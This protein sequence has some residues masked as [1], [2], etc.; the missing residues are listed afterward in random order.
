MNPKRGK[1][2]MRAFLKKR[3]LPAILSLS[4]GLSMALPGSLTALAAGTF[5]TN[6]TN[7]HGLSGTW[8]ETADGYH[9]VAYGPGGNSFAIAD[10]QVGKDDLFTYEAQVSST[11]T[12]PD[13]NASLI[14][15]LKNPQNPAE[16]FYDF[17]I[18]T[19]SNRYIRFDQINGELSS[20][21]LQA[22]ALAEVKDSYQL[23]IVRS[24]Q[25]EFEFFI[26]NASI[27]KMDLPGFEGGYVGMMTND[28]GTYQNV[29]LT[30]DGS[31]QG[32]V[33][34]LTG[35]KAQSGTWT[36]TSQGYKSE[37]AG[38][39][40]FLIS[41]KTLGADDLFTY[42]ADV[43]PLEDN[44][45]LAFGIEDPANPTKHWYCFS[46]VKGNVGLVFEQVN[47]EAVGGLP[48]FVALT[49]EEKAQTTH[50]LKVVRKDAATFAFYI[51]DRLVH[52]ATFA[53]YS[54]G[55]FGLLCTVKAA[56]QNA[57]LTE[58]GTSIEGFQS[59]ITGWHQVSGTWTFTEQG[60]EGV[61]SGNH[62]AMSEKRI[63]ADTLF[64]Y[65]ADMTPKSAASGIVFGVLN[66]ADPVTRWYCFNVVRDAAG[67]DIS[68]IFNQTNGDPGGSIKASALTEDEKAKATYHM[69]VVREDKST[70]KFY[71]DER[72]I[73][74]ET[75]DGFAGGAFGIMSTGNGIFNQVNF[76]DN[77]KVAGEG[78]VSNLS[79]WRGVNGSWGETDNGYHGEGS[80]NVFAMSSKAV[81]SH[82]PFTYEAD[83]EL[84]LDQTAGG[85]TF[86][87]KDPTNPSAKWFCMNVD[88]GGPLS[89]IFA[90]TNGN[91]DFILDYPL[92]DEEKDLT[93]YHLKVVR[94]V[95]D[96]PV[97][98]YLGERLLL[99]KELTTFEGGYFGVMT[100]NAAA[101]FNHVNYTI[102]GSD[103]A[104]TS[105]L[106]GWTPINGTWSVESNGYKGVTGGGDTWSYAKDKE[107]TADEGFIYEADVQIKSGN[108]A[109][110]LIFGVRDPA[111]PAG[112]PSRLY[113]LLAIKDEGKVMAFT[114]KDGSAEWIEVA[115]MTAADKAADIFH[116]RIEYL[117]SK[118]A[119]F[120][121]NGT[122]Y[123]TVAIP[124][125]EGGFFGAM[126]SGGTTATFDN[127][128]YYPAVTPK[129]QGLELIGAEMDT[130]FDAGDHSYW[131][132]VGHSVDAVKVKTQ[133]DSALYEVTVAGQKAN[134][135]VEVNVGL[136]DGLNAVRVI[137]RDPG[138]DLSDTYTVNITREPNP[139]TLYKETARPQFHFT[140]YMY[141][142]NDPNG[143]VY[144][145]ARGEYHLFFQCNRPFDTGVEGL[146]GTTCWGHAVSKDMVNWEEL[147]LAITPDELGFAYS[148][149]GVI[150][151]NNTSG[152]F[153][154][155]PADPNYTPPGSRIVVFYASVAGDTTYGYAKQS[156][157]YSADGGRTFIKYPGNPVVKN[158]GNMYGGGMRDPKVFWYEDASLKDGGIWVMVTVG[159]L[160]IFTSPNLIDWKHCG[161]PQINGQ[162][163]DS[164]CPDLYP[165]PVDGDPDNIKWVYTGGGIFYVLGHMEV[166]G[167]D[168][169]MFVPE[170][171]KLYALN[172]IAD[173]GPG[174]PAPET[175]ATQTF[176]NEKLGR[177]ISISW[178]RDPSMQWKDKNWNSAQS[179]PMEHSLRTVD[180]KVKLF[181]YPA[182]EVKDMRDEKI[183]SLKGVQVDESSENVLK[184]LKATSC[185]MEATITLGT[186]TEVGFKL[187]VGAAGGGQELKIT[188]NKNDGKL[189]VDKMKTGGG[190]YLGVYEPEMSLLDGNKI[191]LRMLLDQIC[192]D[193]YGNDGEAA[194]AGLIY[195][196]FENNG[197]EFFTNGTATLDLDVYSMKA[198]DRTVPD[199]VVPTVLTDLTLSSALLTPNFSADVTEYTATVANSMD[200]IKVLPT[201][202]GDA[203]VTVNGTEVASGAYS[204]DISLSVG[205]NTITVV[206]GEK[207]YTIKVTREEPAPVP[208]VLT[209]LALST[210]TLA[211]NFS[212][213]VTEY[214]ATVANSV[215]SIKV[216]PT[217]TGDAAV[218]VNG[219]EV[220][221]G[222]YSADISLSV[223]ENAITV[224]AGEKT[225]TIK[226]TREDKKPPVT[227]TPFLDGL[228]LSQG[229]L[230]P[231]FDKDVNAYTASVG[232]ATDSIQ[233]KPFYSGEMAV[234]VNGKAVESGAFSE[235]IAL[236]VGENTIE[237]K[238]VMGE[239]ENIYTIVVTR[240]KPADTTK[241]TTTKPS[242]PGGHSSD[243][244]WPEGTTKPGTGKENPQSG[245]ASA[246]PIA[247]LLMAGA[248]GTAV[249]LS[250]K[251]K[252]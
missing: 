7:L 45:G 156:M 199:P 222:E 13:F 247:L 162:V 70:F 109:A 216:L 202:T 206:A 211:P 187:R 179:I 227:E 234:T 192:F 32:F 68:M 86:G 123:K 219:V 155:D 120:Y 41:D 71:L 107:I 33:S 5:E 135:G 188:Y 85:I 142:M 113:S 163:F 97:K 125:F 69:K 169:V 51:G 60:Y 146:N 209:D 248:A 178:L 54:G 231:A 243:W 95:K 134:P 92:T 14:F 239:K 229:V 84:P 204:T 6:L 200:S 226:V 24:S 236:D 103:A 49:D 183:L 76:T 237:V 136:A 96:G 152:L 203:A 47:G 22:S 224:V 174:N 36:E 12:N 129:L 8:S 198:M 90:Q 43:T 195:S 217:Y 158:P 153:V 27:L 23:K 160:H 230:K 100:C 88:R 30:I 218:T 193:V 232:N 124:K 11:S 110:G 173:Q 128:N 126:V 20:N 4:M 238:L 223:G 144:D 73:F 131:A 59:N 98:F 207:T 21:S 121:V 186:A 37:N 119:N 81:N 245:D 94:E 1:G 154:D 29:R 177:T 57:N 105:N 65:E 91:P 112:R 99:E 75:L 61:C 143:L 214:T 171:D 175:Y 78:F 72:L 252:K 35:W 220:A 40:N 182:A 38:G 77:G 46:V 215:D 141:Q 132:E 130:P 194:I 235:A 55:T 196:E 138:S 80:G 64:T 208:T 172:G 147:P 190:S 122:L 39:N 133:F 104:F 197:M 170:T 251:R 180:G 67:N 83:M 62:F 3:V 34:N 63:D 148:G 166:T 233:V 140:P 48:T 118:T 164:E 168:T 127:V 50:H 225:Y 114:H 116:L 89:R 159:D 117:E 139:D 108:H 52:T 145:D 176:N 2:R 184:D 26:D 151:R 101:T 9:G 242:I 28:V 228:E 161:R 56:F 25:T 15:G 221:S 106:T 240:A 111:D 189:Y 79:G 102:N 150:D 191:K 10:E 44:A 149:S 250:R 157:A 115:D 16:R 246:L 167:E 205:E 31:T 213:E 74:T 165:L 87:V 19:G 53:G 17:G 201:Y 66:P 18:M 58:E 185:D 137:V 249:F 82:D 212:T 93:S 42:E 241:P 244:K 181:S 210:G